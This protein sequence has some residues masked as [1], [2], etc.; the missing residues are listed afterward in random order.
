MVGVSDEPAYIIHVFDLTYFSWSQRSKFVKNYEVAMFRRYLVYH[1][2]TLC[3]HV[4]WY[5]LP[6]TWILFH[7]ASNMAARWPSW[8]FNLSP[9]TPIK[10]TIRYYSNFEAR[11]LWG[12]HLWLP[13]NHCTFSFNNGSRLW[14]HK[15]YVSTMVLGLGPISTVS[16][17]VLGLGP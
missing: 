8:K 7:R 15:H 17:M 10:L 4:Y 1:V 11:V 2:L 13:R 6:N 14:A 16:T 3:R 9:I 12:Y 5:P